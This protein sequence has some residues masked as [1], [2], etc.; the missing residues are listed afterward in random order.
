MYNTVG[1]PDIENYNKAMKI[2]QEEGADIVELGIPPLYAKYDGPIIRASYQVVRSKYKSE[3]LWKIIYNTRKDLGIP[4]VL[5]TYLEEWIYKIN[6][7]LDN[8]HKYE[9][10]AILLP[11]L[12]IDFIDE[13]EK[14][15]NLLKDNKIKTVL[16][17]TP[18]IPDHIISKVQGLSDLFLYYGIRPTTGVEIPI[19][20]FTLLRRIK[21]FIKNK[22]VVGFGLKSEDEIRNAVVAGADGVAIGSLIIE[23]IK[24]Y[25]FNVLKEKIKKI[26]LIL[27]EL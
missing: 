26:R 1:F 25:N 12:L 23:Y 4:V 5:L 13:Y 17:V 18:T 3:E 21:G 20:I 15:I 22:L 24:N 2:V 8:L 10:D 19:D 27:N 11:D 7:L 9:I 14:Y 16:F 6:E